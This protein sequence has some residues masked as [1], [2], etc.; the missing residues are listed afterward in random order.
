MLSV[1][2][3][4]P[5]KGIEYLVQAMPRVLD[6]VPDTALL[7]VGP[8]QLPE[9]ANSIRSLATELDLAQNLVMPG[10]VEYSEVQSYMAAADVFVVSSLL[11]GLNKGAVEAA[12]VGTPTVSVSTAG[13]AT[14][15]QEREC[16]LV[17]EPKDPEGLAGAIVRLLRNRLEWEEMSR[18]SLEF[19]EAFTVERTAAG[20]D[21]MLRWAVGGP[22]PAPTPDA[23]SWMT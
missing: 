1:G 19:A 4:I 11:E 5:I 22:A 12:S 18:R 10:Q 2:K 14:Y 9:Y 7:V 21:E 23:A 16:G 20:L 15:L 13:V 17:V 8:S 6:Q 3:I